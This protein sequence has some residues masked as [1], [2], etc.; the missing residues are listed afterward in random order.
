M[1]LASNV[2]VVPAVPSPNKIA[3]DPF[4]CKWGVSIP[5]LPPIKLN[6]CDELTKGAKSL[7]VSPEFALHRRITSP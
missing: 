7:S 5:Y 1:P 3:L 6:T 4:I 2:S